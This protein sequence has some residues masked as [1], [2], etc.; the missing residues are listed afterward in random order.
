MCIGARSHFTDT[1]RLFCAPYPAR[2]VKTAELTSTVLKAGKDLVSIRL[3]GAVH[4]AQ[5][6]LP[7]SGTTGDQARIPRRPDRSFDATLLGYATYDV[8]KRMFTEFELVAFGSHSGGGRRSFEDPV[9]MG[10]VLTLVSDSPV[11]RVE[12]LHFKRYGWK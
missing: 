9:A 12:P 6:D 10:V 1:V 11:D 7:K 2:C 3:N 4:S 8:R 5:D